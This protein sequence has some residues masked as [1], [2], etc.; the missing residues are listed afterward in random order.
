VRRGASILLDDGAVSLQVLDVRGA[1]VRT[2]VVE[3]GALSDHKGINLPGVTVR[4]PALTEKDVDDLR[5]AV[6]LVVDLVALSFVR[7]P[8]DAEAARRVLA[9]AHAQVPLIAKL[10]KPEAVSRLAEVIDAFDGVMVARGDLGVEMPLE[11]VPLV[12]RRAIAIAREKGKPVI[13]ATQMLESMIHATRPT[14]A[15]VSDVAT[16]VLEGADA[17]ML[18]AET[19]VGEHPIEAV[20]MM[21]RIAAT[22]ASEPIVHAPLGAPT[23][24]DAIAEAASRMAEEVG[25]CALVAFTESGSTARRLARHRPSVPILAF[26]PEPTTRRRLA[27]V[28]GVESLVMGRAPDTDAMVAQVERAVLD[29]GR[30]HPGDPIVIVAGT[31]PGVIGT[32][33]TIRVHRLGDG[34]S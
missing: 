26:T 6:A 19:S 31:P 21:A 18:S 25:A 1:D 29:D 28:W 33:N 13:V 27:L 10:E 5:F 16:A 11:E 4:A 12:Q 8:S 24:H 20:A 23:D 15:E 30:G 7:R 9:E 17:V 34:A 14:R 2:R 32:T 3:G 22:A